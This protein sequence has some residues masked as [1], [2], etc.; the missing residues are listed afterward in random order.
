MK[1]NQKDELLRK[2]K[3]LH[4]Y[5]EA[6]V[7]DEGYNTFKEAD[8]IKEAIDAIQAAYPPAQLKPNI[9]FDPEQNINLGRFDV[10]IQMQENGLY[11][12]TISHNGSSGAHYTNVDPKELGRYLDD[13]IEAVLTQWREQ[14]KVIGNTLDETSSSERD[15]DIERD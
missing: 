15:T 14:R 7:C 11:D 2:L 4:K 5:A 10:D 3:I 12:V 6:E 9:S 13:D 8:V 1:F